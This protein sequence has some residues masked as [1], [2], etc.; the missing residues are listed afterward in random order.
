MKAAR[1]SQMIVGSAIWRQKTVF[2]KLGRYLLAGGGMAALF[3]FLK[4]LA[5]RQ[6]TFCFSVS[7]CSFSP[8]L[9]GDLIVSAGAWAVIFAL[10]GEIL[11][12]VASRL[13]RFKEKSR[14]LP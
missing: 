8:N 9:L 12:Q 10:G 14:L 7:G 4:L 11:V 13:E 5:G 3:E 2:A 1:G 6:S